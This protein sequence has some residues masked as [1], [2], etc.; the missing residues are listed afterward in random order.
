[1]KYLVFILGSNGYIRN[2]LLKKFIR[3]NNFVNN[4]HRSQNC[5][6]SLIWNN[7]EVNIDWP[8]QI[9]DKTKIKLSDQDKNAPNL[10]EISKSNFF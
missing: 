3:K 4:N 2:A 1:M 10:R 9:I 5:E 6:K 8:S 7:E